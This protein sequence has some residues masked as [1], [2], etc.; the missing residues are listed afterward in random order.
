M[1]TVARR[2]VD[3]SRMQRNVVTFRHTPRVLTDTRISETLRSGIWPSCRRKRLTIG[4]HG[5]GCAQIDAH[6]S[7]AR[8]LAG[9]IES[10]DL[11]V[12]QDQQVPK[13]P[14]HWTEMEL[15]VDP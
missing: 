5:V 12:R 2:V 14:S 11:D 15:S 1:T 7:H 8:R 3:A 6:R 9:S 4:M 13:F 10:R